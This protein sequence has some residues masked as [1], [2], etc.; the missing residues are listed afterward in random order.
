VKMKITV[1]KQVLM[2]CALLCASITVFAQGEIQNPTF[3]FWKTNGNSGTDSTMHFIGTTDPRGLRFKINNIQAG[4]LGQS[5]NTFFGLRAG[6]NASGTY[7]NVAIGNGALSGLVTANNTI[8]IGDSALFSLIDGT[9]NTALGSK[10]LFA[11]IGGIGNVA[12][13]SNSMQFTTY[14]FYNVGIGV[15]ALYQN[16]QG[17]ANIAI[18]GSALFNNTYS[19]SNIAIGQQALSSMLFSNSNA[20]Y[21]GDNVAIGIFSLSATNPTSTA[22][23]IQ[24]VAV[25]TNTLSNNT[26]GVGNTA[27]GYLSG[28]SN[29]SGIRNTFIGWNARTFQPGL[30]NATAVGA[31]A[32]VV[33][34]N[35]MVLGSVAGVNGATS[36]VKVGMGTNAPNT[37][38]DINGDL[39]LRGRVL[40]LSNG[41]NNDVS[42]DSNST[43]YVAAGGLPYA[44]TGFANGVNGKIITIHNFTNQKLTV[45]DQSALSLVANRIATGAGDLLLNDTSSV[46][47][48]YNSSQLRW[49]VIGFSNGR[50][51]N[52]N[53]HTNI[54]SAT[55]TSLI[56]TTF[57]SIT[58]MPEMTITYVPVDT[59]AFVTFSAAG[60]QN[61][62][63]QLPVS[64][65]LLKNGV[66]QK[67]FAASMEDVSAPVGV[68]WEASQTFPISV[69]PGLTTTF[70]IN[71]SSPGNCQVF[72]GPTLT[73]SPFG[74][75]RTLVVM[76]ANG[77]GANTTSTPNPS[78]TLY[79]KLN[80]NSNTSEITDYIG[81]NDAENLIFRVN[82]V[83]RMKLDTLGR[84]QIFGNSN[85]TVVGALAGFNLT[86]S[87]TG[88]NNTFLGQS[89]G[90]SSATARDN[91]FI[92]YTSGSGRTKSDFN[93]I[94][95]ALTG[96]SFDLSGDSSNYNVLVGY[97]AGGGITGGDNNVVIGNEAARLLSFGTNNTAIGDSSLFKNTLGDNNTA[98]GKKA[99]F[100]VD[101]AGYNT[102]IGA[103]S[104]VSSNS[105]FRST[106][107]G[108]NAI[109]SASNTLILGDTIYKPLVGIGVTEVGTTL[110]STKFEIASDNE[111]RDNILFRLHGSGTPTFNFQR[112]FGTAA[113]P[114]AMGLGSTIGRFDFYGYDG[115]N[116]SLGAFITVIT[117]STTSAGEVPSTINFGTRNSTSTIERMRLNRNGYLGIGT[118]D[119]DTRLVVGGAVSYLNGTFSVTGNTTLNVGDRTYYRITSTVVP[120]SAV[121]SLSAGLETGQLLIIE[122]SSATAANGFQFVQ[123]TST[124][125]Q[126]SAT[127]GTIDALDSND[128]ITFI[129][130]GTRWTRISTVA[131]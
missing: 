103:E 62:C 76:E 123:G 69:T 28:S 39:A 55:G 3:P 107:I 129:W 48:Q 120:A 88:G 78:D 5:G 8:A 15:G 14:G 101:T 52:D 16:V 54:Y 41:D 11:N 22:N 104:N 82:A 35:S 118:T 83:N 116:Y 13:G 4:F 33:Q 12:I 45:K 10:A 7:S 121:L 51:T 77:N 73:S 108:H 47:L 29:I 102:F 75:H 59:V 18:G 87:S 99:G 105:I 114:T 117:D 19:G 130:N 68:V 44:I 40:S 81:T 17:S 20:V 128:V 89:S 85:N 94:I 96:N 23:G 109:V 66:T 115:T 26:T 9:E 86:G 57:T 63:G 124:N 27:V 79:W 91:V 119:P 38:L 65:Y 72:N 1:G 30:L 84:L 113:A 80:G 25:G 131:N 67:I 36:N 42:T 34:N 50:L 60:R 6:S 53:V 125:V 127:A 24:N 74:S 58:S 61:S 126:I 49:V 32:T 56:A 31:N 100:T 2:I 21:S 64:F 93:V 92:G 70:S 97:R 46:T 111:S 71:W 37:R 98:L 95:G 106:A 122:N 110:G 43:Y 112:S 90:S